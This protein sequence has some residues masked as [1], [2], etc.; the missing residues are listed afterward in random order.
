MILRHVENAQV[1]HFLYTLF[2]MRLTPFPTLHLNETHVPIGASL[3]TMCETMATLSLPSSRNSRQTLANGA[4]LSF[5][6]TE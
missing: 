6:H 3:L 2:F 5:E 4:D 1:A